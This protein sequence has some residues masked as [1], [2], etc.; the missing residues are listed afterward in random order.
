M[1]RW[2]A[3]LA[4]IFL[5]TVMADAELARVNGAST[6][7]D[8]GDLS[9]DGLAGVWKMCFEPGLEELDEPSEGFLVLLPNGIFYEIRWDC[10][11]DAPASTV[12][13]FTVEGHRVVF[14]PERD[15]ES[16]SSI[17]RTY[18]PA[19]SAVFF[20]DLTAQ[21]AETEALVV[22]ST[23]DYAYCRVYPHDS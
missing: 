3:V 1:T 7:G 6:T 8:A 11:V 4:A 18:D 5:A 13:E 9:R 17:T 15:E 21:P 12:G 19:E 2:T 14:E 10:C 20:D 22:G 23:L 16:E